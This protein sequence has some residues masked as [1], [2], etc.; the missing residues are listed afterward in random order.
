VSVCEYL[1]A[2]DLRVQKKA[3]EPLEQKLQVTELLDMGTEHGKG[4]HTGVSR[5][6]GRR[7]WGAHNQNALFPCMELPENK[8][9]KC[10]LLKLFKHNRT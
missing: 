7:S 6:V 1:S 10:I 5:R 4:G 9:K 3:S 8:Y 2:G